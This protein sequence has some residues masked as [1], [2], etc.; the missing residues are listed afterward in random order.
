MFSE[1]SVRPHEREYV[2]A[3]GLP[4]GAGLDG[5]G[6]TVFQPCPAFSERRCSLY[7]VGRP[8]TCHSYVC[9]LL[10]SFESGHGTIDDALAVIQQVRSLARELEVEMCMP[11][12]TYNRRALNEYLRER[13]PWERPSEY[14]RFLVALYEFNV[15]GNK[16]FDFNPAEVETQAADAGSRVAASYLDRK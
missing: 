13:R 15:L 3:L 7:E 4:V 12:G 14:P 9:G 6:T 2:E 11:L 10:Q 5:S 16:Y 8:A 1:I